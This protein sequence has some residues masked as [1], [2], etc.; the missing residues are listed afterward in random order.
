[1]TI[2]KI[3]D[4]LAWMLGAVAL[5]MGVVFFAASVGGLSAYLVVGNSFPSLVWNFSDP[6][7]L[8]G[9]AELPVILVL[10]GLPAIAL[11]MGG[12]GRP[13]R[14]SMAAWA[15]RSGQWAL[16]FAGL[17]TSLIALMFACRQVLF[18]GM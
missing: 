6:S 13:L 7:I 1:M 4:F 3:L 11:S 2:T 15:V 10:L 16:A 8:K 5:G 14:A 12:G 17:L 9:M 18:P